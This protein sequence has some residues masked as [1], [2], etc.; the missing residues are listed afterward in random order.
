MIR[1]MLVKENQAYVQAGAG[2]V[3][4]SIPANEY[5]ESM[6]KARAL[7]NAK[8]LAEEKLGDGN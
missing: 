8:E 5:K 4:D 2:I 3:I 1:T 7:W 6:K